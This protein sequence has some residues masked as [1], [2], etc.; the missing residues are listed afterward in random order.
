KR[1]QPAPPCVL[2]GYRRDSA[3]LRGFFARISVPAAAL[4]EHGAEWFQAYPLE[5]L[6]I[7]DRGRLL[8][9]IV[10][11]PWLG[12]VTSLALSHHGLRLAELEALLASPHLGRLRRLLLRSVALTPDGVEALARSPVLRQLR[13]L[14]LGDDYF[15]PRLAD[16]G[17]I[18]AGL[19]NRF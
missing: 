1:W 16:A 14:D 4:L 15:G 5:E 8:G 11:Q 6:R 19:G 2:A 18:S 13:H 3:F 10:R 12:Q 7:T 9:E 17:P